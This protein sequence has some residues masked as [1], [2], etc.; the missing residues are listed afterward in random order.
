MRQR[1]ADRLEDLLRGGRGIDDGESGRLRIFV[2]HKRFI[3]EWTWG[4]I[5]GCSDAFVEADH[6]SQWLADYTEFI[7]AKLAERRP[8]R[9]VLLG[10]SEGAEVIPW[11]AQRIAGVTHA[12]LLSSGGMDPLDAYRMQAEK[13]RSSDDLNIVASLERG[14]TGESGTAAKRI[15]GRTWRYWL[16]LRELKPTERLLALTIPILVGMGEADSLMPIETV[17]HVR[18]RFDEVGKTNLTI[19]T[20]PNADHSLFDQHSGVLRMSDFFHSMD[21]WL[22]Q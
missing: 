12:V 4:R 3:E 1:S 13:H 9:V 20:Y 14:A 16:E 17:W 8:R 2:L 7:E 11:L 21:L 19:M 18:D 22:M 10:I 6:P 15:G 5:G